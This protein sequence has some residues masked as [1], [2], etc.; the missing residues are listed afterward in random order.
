MTTR[1]LFVSQSNASRSQ[2]AEALARIWASGTA[3]AYSAGI[4]PSR[5]IGAR[6]IVS[7][8]E[9][10]YDLRDH[11]P[12]PVKAFAGEDFDVVVLIGCRSAE[13]LRGAR[14]ELWDDIPYPAGGGPD[15]VRLLRDMLAERVRRLLG[16]R[17]TITRDRGS[18]K[19]VLLASQARPV[20]MRVA[21]AL[22]HHQLYGSLSTR[23]D[24]ILDR[25]AFAL[26][27][28]AGVYILSGTH[29]LRRFA[30]ED[31]AG[32]N[33]EQGG[34][35]FRSRAGTLFA[36]VSM[37]RGKIL[38]AIGALERSRDAPDIGP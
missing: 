21:T 37:P 28:V 9:L 33:F 25:T 5:E 14:F 26:S 1:I 31:T 4:R 15:L 32:G 19:T 35:A 27:Q 17:A 10:G 20:P 29:R 3:H 6:A 8:R 16:P 34:D 30:Q 38:G 11:R 2:M 18:M 13:P 7:M 12:L 23:N 24:E 36:P 22:A